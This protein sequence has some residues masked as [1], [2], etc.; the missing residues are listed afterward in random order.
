[1]KWKTKLLLRGFFVCFTF[2]KQDYL[3][4]ECLLY[5]YTSLVKLKWGVRWKWTKAW[6]LEPPQATIS[7]HLWLTLWL[8]CFSQGTGQQVTKNQ[9]CSFSERGFST[10]G[11][12]ISKVTAGFTGCW[13]ASYLLVCVTCQ[14]TKQAVTSSS[15]SLPAAM[16]EWVW[17]YCSA[18]EYTASGRIVPQYWTA[19]WDKWI[20]GAYLSRSQY[21]YHVFYTSGCYTRDFSTP[22]ALRTARECAL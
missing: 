11:D 19:A 7:V 1:M 9:H 8:L 21:F 5:I 14:I 3:F 4:F 12:V 22:L 13:G 18:W 10:P 15:Y 2:F 20:I 16:N 6:S 17:C